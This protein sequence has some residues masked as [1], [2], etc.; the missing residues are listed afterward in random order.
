MGSGYR[1]K[2]GKFHPINN[3]SPKPS[4]EQTEPD[5]QEPKM[6]ESKVEE[7]KKKKI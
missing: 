5:E 3:D 4:S 2:S 7:L 6:D 1:D